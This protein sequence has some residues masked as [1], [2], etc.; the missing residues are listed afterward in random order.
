VRKQGN[1]NSL[2]EIFEVKKISQS[3]YLETGKGKLGQNI[4]NVQ[5]KHFL[6]TDA[7]I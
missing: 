3:K 2:N 7:K 4:E 6:T 1:V 5:A